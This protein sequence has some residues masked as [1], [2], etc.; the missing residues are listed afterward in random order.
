MA[1]STVLSQHISKIVYN[2]SAHDV[3]NGSSDE[4]EDRPVRYYETLM[5]TI[6]I[7]FSAWEGPA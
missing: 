3:T 1:Q 2:V 4:Q 7:W 5:G 6:M